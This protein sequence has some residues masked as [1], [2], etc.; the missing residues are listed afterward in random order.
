MFVLHSQA[1]SNTVLSLASAIRQEKKIKSIKI[2]RKKLNHP[3]LQTTWSSTQKVTRNR[4][5][6]LL[7]L[8][9]VAGYELNTQK[10]ST[11]CLYSSNEHADTEIKRPILFTIVLKTEILRCEP[12]KTYRN[13]MLNTTQYWWKKR[14]DLLC[15]LIRRFEIVKTP[16]ILQIPAK[17][18]V[19]TE[20]SSL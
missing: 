16:I 10:E 13:Y 19:D 11:V 14:G 7:E 17:L 12:K 15:A 18:F 3:Y 2:E 1:S 8:Y 9:E 20:R 4:P 6:K 5:K